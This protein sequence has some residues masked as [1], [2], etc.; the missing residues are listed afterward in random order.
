MKKKPPTKLDWFAWYAAQYAADTTHLSREADY[1][2]RRI[3]DHIFIHDQKTCRVVDDELLLVGIARCSREEWPAIR[4]ALIDGP[5]A[6]LE[7]PDGAEGW[8]FSP[9]LAE[10]IHKAKKKSAQARK[11]VAERERKRSAR[12]SDDDHPFSGGP[13]S[14]RESKRK[15]Q[16]SETTSPPVRERE[17]STTRAGAEPDSRL[18][19]DERAYTARCREIAAWK[20]TLPR[21][22]VENEA[23]YAAEFY[24]EYGMSDDYWQTVVE[25]MES[26]AVAVA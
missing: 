10:E 23:A 6:M 26:A 22:I 4:H 9:K 3:I 14:K 8:L 16:P 21:V 20:K 24:R 12:S 13:S 19:M 1:A 7:K 5:M 11:A 18:P 2:Y 17:S 25:R 15:K